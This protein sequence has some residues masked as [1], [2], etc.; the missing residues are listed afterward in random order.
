E[1]M[2][3]AAADDVVGRRLG[4]VLKGAESNGR[5]LADAALDGNGA[6]ITAMVES[7]DGRR[8]PVAVTGAPLRDASGE[9]VGRVVVLR[10]TSREHEA[11]RMKSEFLANV[12]H[13]LR[14][15]LTPIKGYTEILRRKQFPRQ[16][17]KTFLDGIMES[18]KRLERIVEILVDFAAM[19][20]GRLKPHVEPIDL[21]VFL[22]TLVDGWKGRN[23]SHRFVRKVPADMPPALGD[24]R[25]LRKC[26]DELLDNAVKF[27]PGGGDIEIEAE[28]ATAAGRR[29]PAGVRILV[30]DRGIG[31]EPSKMGT[32]FQDFRQGDG[33]ETRTFGGLGLGLSYARRVVLAHR[34]EITATSR[35]GAGSTFT[36]TLPVAPAAVRSLPRRA[37]TPVSKPKASRGATP[38]PRR[39][40]G[41]KVRAKKPA[42][43]RTVIRKKVAAA[44]T[45]PRRRGR[46]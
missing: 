46:R 19:E 41:R 1:R 39:G 30:K 5:G 12:S 23:T 34:G 2:L 15:P 4:E 21:K 17:A 13:E 38:K 42:A 44:K 29:R 11:E 45:P 31:I 9:T 40:T 8:V 36:V 33:S 10:D 18:T 24:E 32:L 35:P 20:A 43:A 27:S 28:P 26:L 14:T 7:S 16:K 6:G 25:L 37:R 22:G 3:G